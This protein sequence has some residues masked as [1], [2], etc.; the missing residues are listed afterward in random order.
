MLAHARAHARAH[1]HLRLPP[2][3]PPP[4]H[5]PSPRRE[6]EVGAAPGTQQFFLQF[7]TR[8]MHWSGEL[9]LRVSTVTR[10]WIEGSAVADLIT[11][12]QHR[13]QMVIG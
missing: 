12:E 10:R 9:R 3:A 4:T 8:Y 5:P 11:G 7:L 13:Q 1:P 6:S 2:R